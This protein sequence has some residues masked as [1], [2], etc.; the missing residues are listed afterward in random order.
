MTTKPQTARVRVAAS[1]RKLSLSHIA[2]RFLIYLLLSVLSFVFLVPFFWLVSTS[3]KPRAQ[4][5]AS[6][7]IPDPIVW[8]NY[9][10]VLRNTDF[11]LWTRNSLIVTFLAVVSVAFSSALVAYP[12][13]KMSFP[14][15][16]PLFALILA[17]MMLPGAVTMVPTFLI[18]KKL[19]A[20]NTFYPLWAGNLFGSAFYIFMLRQF[21]LTIPNDLKEAAIV[22][23]AS[24][25]RIF[26]SV[27]LPLV[28]PAMLAVILFEFVAKW[29]D[30]MTPLIYLNDPRKYTL[31]LG[32]ATFMN[33]AG[34]ET[35]WDL[36][37]ASS[38]LMTI[39]I[40]ILFFLGQRFF[41]EGI[42]TTG[43]KG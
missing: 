31:P 21:F 10:E 35:R 7:W 23:G 30:Y 16:G 5:F 42:A 41:I 8:G 27:M 40:I 34:F 29:N 18:W 32:V 28:K 1:P 39:P 20:V 3:L 43:L 24:H 26:W 14:L 12:F 17:T 19:N 25:L 37:M 22:D 36:W 11:V 38:V 15:K 6:N 9:A 33:S 13:A 4:I 2:E